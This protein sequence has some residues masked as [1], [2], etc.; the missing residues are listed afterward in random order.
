MQAV[1]SPSPSS[2]STDRQRLSGEDRRRQLLEHAIELFAKHGFKGT[3]TKDIAAACGVSEG[4]LFRH[5]ATKEDLYHAILEA[6]NEDDALVRCMIGQI[7]ESFRQNSAFHRL[8]MY[9]RLEGHVL[10]GMFHER[11]GV[12]ARDFLHGYVE[13]RQ[14]DGAFREGDPDALM[15]QALAPVLHYSMCKYVFGIDGLPLSEEEMVDELARLA[16]AGLRAPRKKRNK[17]ASPRV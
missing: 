2:S 6:R 8:M 16:M 5:F 13:R 12:P 17:T 11:M 4:I 7:V 1:P 10:A 14:R 9:A 15:L 3:R